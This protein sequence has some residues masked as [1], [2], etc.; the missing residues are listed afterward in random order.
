MRSPLFGR[1]P[2]PHPWYYLF[3]SFHMLSSLNRTM[4]TLIGPSV[5]ALSIHSFPDRLLIYYFF[6]GGVAQ[7][8]KYVLFVVLGL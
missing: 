7:T 1:T 4:V 3:N 5:A 6:A 8:L 2:T